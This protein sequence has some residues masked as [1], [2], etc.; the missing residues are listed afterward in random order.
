M[1]NRR[2]LSVISSCVSFVLAIT[3]RFI[4]D[5]FP[6]WPCPRLFS[7][8]LTQARNFWH[9]VLTQRFDKFICVDTVKVKS[10]DFLLAYRFTFLLA[11][12]GY[13]FYRSPPRFNDS[14]IYHAGKSENWGETGRQPIEFD[15]VILIPPISITLADNLETRVHSLPSNVLSFARLQQLLFRSCWFI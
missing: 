5:A 13:S 10:F 11:T 3:R 7:L 1:Q 9:R 4:G 15:P 8:G 2:L 12:N 14:T 6:G